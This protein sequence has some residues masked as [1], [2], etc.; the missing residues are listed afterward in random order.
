V[1]V[2]VLNLKRFFAGFALYH[3]LAQKSDN[4]WT[5]ISKALY[6]LTNFTAFHIGRLNT[7]SAEQ[8]S[9]LGV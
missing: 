1:V 2:Q 6:F 9:T 7:E 4:D 8:T 3:V 5:W